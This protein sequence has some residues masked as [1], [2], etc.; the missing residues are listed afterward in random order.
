ME[1]ALE[2]RAAALEDELAA[3]A[4]EH[5]RQVAALTERADALRTDTARLASAASAAAVRLRAADAQIAALTSRAMF[6][7]SALRT[8]LSRPLSAVEAERRR[9]ASTQ[10]ESLAAAAARRNSILLLQGAVTPP[11]SPYT[12]R[13]AGTPLSLSVSP[14]PRPQGSVSNRAGLLA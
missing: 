8:A 7:E 1:Y 12:D 4:A 11:A 9:D 2:L 3:Q 14:P 5:A 13:T 6:A 10:T